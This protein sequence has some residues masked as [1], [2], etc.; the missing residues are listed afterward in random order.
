M[1]GA[2][3][4]A[5]RRFDLSARLPD[6]V[7]RGSAELGFLFADAALLTAEEG[8][9]LLKA[10]ARQFSDEE[11]FGVVVDDLAESRRTTT[12]ILTIEPASPR[13]L[14]INWLDQEEVG[15]QGPLYVDARVLAFC[16]STGKW[17]V[18]IDQDRE[19]AVLGAPLQS[20]NGVAASTRPGF[21]WLTAREAADLLAPS[22]HPD[23]VS[24]ELL[25]QLDKAY[26]RSS[27]TGPNP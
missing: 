8:W 2:A 17:G 24:P 7:F 18:W 15:G 6:Q 14:F 3:S 25:E 19:L 22:F 11:I 1:S 23:P 20:L 27:L 21:S 26:G 10:C 9:G 16:G 5:G 12:P 4:I 13:E